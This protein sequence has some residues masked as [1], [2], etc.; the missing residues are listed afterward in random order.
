M[1]AVCSFTPAPEDGGGVENDYVSKELLYEHVLSGY[2]IIYQRKV[3]IQNDGDW[4][5]N[6]NISNLHFSHLQ[7]YRGSQVAVY[8][9]FNTPDNKFTASTNQLFLVKVEIIQR[10]STVDNTFIQN[11]SWEIFLRCVAS[12]ALWQGRNNPKRLLFR[13]HPK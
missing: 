9:S 1:S 13:C 12:I 8:S 7:F 11:L 4:K 5:L 6:R 10:C 2:L 3:P